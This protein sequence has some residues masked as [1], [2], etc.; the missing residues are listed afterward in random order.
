MY[1]QLCVNVLGVRNLPPNKSGSHVFVCMKGMKHCGDFQLTTSEVDNIMVT[2][3]W[4]MHCEK[5][6]EGVVFE[7]WSHPTG[8]FKSLTGSKLLG[9][10]R[11][12]FTTLLASPT[13]AIQGWYAMSKKSGGHPILYDLDHKPPAVKLAASI[14]PPVSAPYLLRAVNGKVQSDIFDHVEESTRAWH[15]GRWMT[16]IVLDHYSEEKYLVRVR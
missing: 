12:S 3:P 15:M 13:F 6:T 10:V 16:R 11:I 2:S 7:L 1:V 9:E 8:F 14:T 4:M 5:S